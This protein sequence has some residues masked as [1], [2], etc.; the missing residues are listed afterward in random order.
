M[1]FQEGKAVRFKEIW[2]RQMSD[3]AELTGLA[4]DPSTNRLAACHRGGVLQM[5]TLN[6]TMAEKEVVSHRIRHC[7]P[8]A[9]AFGAMH[10]DERELLVFGLPCGL[11]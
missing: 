2:N 5:F 6:A 3:P 10:G 7:V 8:Q 1:R 4:F 11:V 9:V